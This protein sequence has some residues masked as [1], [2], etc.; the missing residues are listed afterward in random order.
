MAIERADLDVLVGHNELSDQLTLLFT[1]LTELQRVDPDGQWQ[2]EF[3]DEIGCLASEAFD[4]LH[5]YA[6]GWSVPD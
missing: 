5:R 1:V 2:S 6:P 3:A 4:T